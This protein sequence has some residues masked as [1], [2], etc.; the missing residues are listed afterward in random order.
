ML[1]AAAAGRFFEAAALP[2]AFA[3][4]AAA[5]R[6]NLQDSAAAGLRIFLLWSATAA[7]AGL[8]ILSP[9]ALLSPGEAATDGKG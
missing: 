8:R 2:L 7:A 4:T 9:R 3:F 5:G 6:F 1:E